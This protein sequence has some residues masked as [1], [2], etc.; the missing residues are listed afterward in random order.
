MIHSEDNIFF[1]FVFMTTISDKLFFIKIL[2]L[3]TFECLN[4]LSYQNRKKATMK[5][6]MRELPHIHYRQ[7][8]YQLS[9]IY[10]LLCQHIYYIYLNGSISICSFIHI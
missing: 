7:F 5:I 6:G 10:K 3:N 4:R 1:Q 8:Q 2:Y 9:V